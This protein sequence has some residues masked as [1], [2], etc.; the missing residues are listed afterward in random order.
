LSLY[1]QISI[2]L[3]SYQKNLLAVDYHYKKQKKKKKK[4]TRP[5]KMCIVGAQFQWIHG[6][7]TVYEGL[8]HLRLRKH[9]KRGSRKI[10]R[11]RI[12][13]SFL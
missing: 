12:S 7:G 11:Q 8:W 4:K 3:I 2:V 9:C 5:I 10:I 1:P 13:G 6:T